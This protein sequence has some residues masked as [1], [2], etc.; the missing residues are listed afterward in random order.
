VYLHPNHMDLHPELSKPTLTT[1]Q[2]HQTGYFYYP[3]KQTN[4]WKTIKSIVHPKWFEQKE[5]TKQ[6]TISLD[7]RVVAALDQ[8]HGR[9]WTSKE[10]KWVMKKDDPEGVGFWLYHVR[11][12]MKGKERWVR[13]ED[14]HRFRDKQSKVGRPA[15]GTAYKVRR[16]IWR[17]LASSNL[18][19]AFRHYGHRTPGRKEVVSLRLPDLSLAVFELLK[20]HFPFN[21]EHV[22]VLIAWSKLKN[23]SWFESH[24]VNPLLYAERTEQLAFLKHV[25]DTSWKAVLAGLIEGRYADQ[26]VVL[27]NVQQTEENEN[28]L[29]LLNGHL[30][31]NIT[32]PE[33]R[34][35]LSEACTHCKSKA[36][37]YCKPNEFGF[38]RCG[39][40]GLVIDV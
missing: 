23:I 28:G 18:S 1:V 14:I 36:W 32:I 19:S 22:H 37:T 5:F 11:T 35:E 4:G 21:E 27:S 30:G 26:T 10:P 15:S 34:S 31:N 33:Y 39:D 7:S 2:T 6:Y 16:A 8:E 12:G 20:A 40:C 9:R 24:D 17:T 29:L 13:S 38:A 25:S 3:R